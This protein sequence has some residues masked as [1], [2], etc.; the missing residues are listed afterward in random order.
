VA[1]ILALL[2]INV[3][4]FVALAALAEEGLVLVLLLEALLLHLLHLSFG[5]LTQL[6][7][8]GHRQVLLPELELGLELIVLSELREE[9][10]ISVRRLAY[11]L[12]LTIHPVHDFLALLARHAIKIEVLVF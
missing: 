8:K 3:V 10:L 1:L 4:H 9:R 12:Q 6:I 7:G 2:G 5:S 11:V